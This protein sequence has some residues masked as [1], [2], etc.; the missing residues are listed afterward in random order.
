MA[1]GKGRKGAEEISI[2]RI[3]LPL[4][5]LSP[6]PPFPQ[7]QTEPPHVGC[8]RKNPLNTPAGFLVHQSVESGN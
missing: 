2:A 4:C 8:Y 3:G 7:I 6:F 5:S 1:E